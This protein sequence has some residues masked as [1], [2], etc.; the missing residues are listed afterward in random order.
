[1]GDN[2]GPGWRWANLDDVALER[3]EREDLP[4]VSR[5]ERYVGSDDID[6]LEWTVQRW[7]PTSEVTSAAKV[8]HPDDYLF[9]RRSLYAS[10]F[11]ERAARAEF[12]GLCS[13]DILPLRERPGAIEPGFLG[14]VLNHPRIWEYVVKHATGSITKRIKWRDLSEYRF[15]LP[16]VAE[17]RR[18][19]AL[20]AAIHELREGVRTSLL[21][22]RTVRDSLVVQ[23][24]AHNASSRRGFLNDLCVDITVGIVVRPA[25]L[26]VDRGTGVPA[27][28]MK[29][30]QR[31]QIDTT[32]LLNISHEGHAAHAKSALRSGDVVA[33]RSSGSVERTGDA[34]V[35]PPD[36]EGSNCIDLLIA[37]PGSLI[38]P[39][40]LCEYLNAPTTRAELVGRSSG[41]MQK[42][43]NVGA[44]KRLT[45]PLIADSAQR[46]FLD[47][48]AEL[49]MTITA[50]ESRSAA[51]RR[52][53]A[54]VV[55]LAGGP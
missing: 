1:M 22:S 42:H 32:D 29:N 28:I 37:R 46:E 19:V 8:F 51:L 7:R 44:L 13:G 41:T 52:Q 54:T 47:S 17:Q 33:V 45:I 38:R 3:T 35:V 23:R 53:F 16:P 40:Y 21:A 18:F 15:A 5:Y 50:L 4:S 31:G 55:S 30:V 12:S 10:D 43:L 11:R 2:L 14:A 48:L 25:D 39:E 6:R 34:A 9:V 26:Y 49:G 27:L 20:L 24:F 36:L